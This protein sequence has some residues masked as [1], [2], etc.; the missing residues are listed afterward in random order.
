MNIAGGLQ[1]IFLRNHLH[2]LDSCRSSTCLEIK[3]LLHRNH[4]YIEVPVIAFRDQSLEY[5]IRIFAAF[6]SY[7]DTVNLS[8]FYFIGMFG[9]RNVLRIQ[10]AHHIGFHFLV[11]CHISL[12]K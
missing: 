9:I 5:L 10:N 3:F 12:R 7:R 11:L 6:Q 4:K 1:K 2:A 8:V